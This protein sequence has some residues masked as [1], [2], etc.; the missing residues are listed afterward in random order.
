[1]Y[2]GSPSKHWPPKA[3][4]P[5][6]SYRN[7]T[8]M[9]KQVSPSLSVCMYTDI[10]TLN[11]HTCWLQQAYCRSKQKVEMRKDDTIK[12]RRYNNVNEC[13]VRIYGDFQTLNDLSME[14][15]SKNGKTYITELKQVHGGMQIFV[16]VTIKD[17][18]H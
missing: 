2:A 14:H 6:G 3:S 18:H 5:H 7:L 13:P 8:D 15:K 11:I 1:M 16:S 17:H 10:H 12:F 4:S 9:C